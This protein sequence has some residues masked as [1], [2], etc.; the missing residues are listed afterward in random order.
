[1][2]AAAGLVSSTLLATASPARA[3]GNGMLVV[4]I[5]DQYGRPTEGAMSALDSAGNGQTEDGATGPDDFLPGVT[6]T[7]TVAPGDYA[8]LAVTTWG[9]LSCFGV[10]PCNIAAGST[11]IT[12]VVSV[13][14]ESTI[15]QTLQV[16][17]PTISG[18]P[19]VG[20]P[21]SLT[22]PAGLTALQAV[23]HNEGDPITQQWMRGGG[24][25]A[26]AT[27]PSYTPVPADSAQAIT[28]R[29]SP[30]TVQ[31]A[32]PLAY[33]LTVTPFTTNAIPLARFVPTKT[34]TKVKLPHNL[35]AGD[36]VSLKVVVKAKG[37]HPDGTVTVKAGRSAVRRTLS[38]GSTFVNLPR[39]AAGTYKITV[40]YAGTDYFAKSR[41]KKKIT[42]L[43]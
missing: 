14:A 13:P 2:L 8:F 33:G 4:T 27:G 43:E 16:T 40:K 28:A 18:N 26:N 15:H 36:R 34:K 30:S 22:I 9:G 5:V 37:A 39:L 31:N 38:D 23:G 7:Y 29:L 11:D 35:R 6:H 20:S 25:I 12:P 21:L 24:A 41:F 19:A 42:V 1:V 17:V 10:S 3:V 32:L